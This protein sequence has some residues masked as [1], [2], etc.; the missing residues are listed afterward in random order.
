MPDGPLPEVG[1][2]VRRHSDH[3]T[4]LQSLHL[5]GTMRDDEGESSDEGDMYV[6]RRGLCHCS[7]HR[8]EVCQLCCVD[9]RPTNEITRAGKDADIDAI[10]ERHERIQEAEHCAMLMQ[11]RSE[12]NSSGPLM[13]GSEEAQRLFA[14]AADRPPSGS[15]VCAHCK[16]GGKLLRCSRCKSALYCNRE[17]QVADFPRHKADCRRI[18]AAAINTPTGARARSEART[19]TTWAKLEALGGMPATGKT[20]ELRIMSEPIPFLRYSFDGKDRKGDV[21][22]VAFYL[23]NGTAPPP[24]LALGKVFRWRNPSFH[25]FMD[26]ST[27][28]RIEDEDLVNITVTDS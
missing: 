21:R 5:P 13:L 3:G 19:P 23:D 9:H 20:L 1:K 26:G 25:Q 15:E 28:A 22:R 27:G 2:A 10:L 11:R 4:L 16:R 7:A 24:A 14:A 8:R 17:H 12:G 18:A 6:N